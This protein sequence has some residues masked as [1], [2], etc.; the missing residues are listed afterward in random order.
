MSKQENA[1]NE[2]KQIIETYDN[3]VRVF[4]TYSTLN[5]LQAAEM[6]CFFVK[7]S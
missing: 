4:D 3:I 5:S 2:L 7:F 1:I 6:R